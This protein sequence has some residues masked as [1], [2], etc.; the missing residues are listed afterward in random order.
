MPTPSDP[1]ARRV[2]AL[3][4]VIALTALTV[5]AAVL[6]RLDATRAALRSAQSSCAGALR[7]SPEEDSPLSEARPKRSQP[8][9]LDSD[10]ELGRV[11][12]EEAPSRPSPAGTSSG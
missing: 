9:P 10:T 1:H 4:A 11:D 8:A 12:P 5:A 6:H 7:A 2:A 3:S